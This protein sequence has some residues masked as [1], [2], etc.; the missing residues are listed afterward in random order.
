MTSL[1]ILERVLWTASAAAAAFALYRAFQL[2]LHRRF[3]MFTSYL[4]LLV[5][6][7]LGLVWID[8]YS[9]VYRVAWLTFEPLVAVG[10]AAI[11]IEA[12]LRLSRDFA[13]DW[14]F[15]ALVASGAAA[16]G[17][18]VSLFLSQID[19][20]WWGGALQLA[21]LSRAYVASTLAV[22]LGAAVVFGHILKVRTP[23]TR[24]RN[25]ALHLSLFIAYLAVTAAGF[26]DANVRDG[27][28]GVSIPNTVMSAI[29]AGVFVWWGLGMK[30]EDEDSDAVIPPS[31][32]GR[33]AS[34]DA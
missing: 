4:L 3:P 7:Y 34:S 24:G 17:V 8:A 28:Q 5:A 23:G 18:I 15:R 33:E 25:L 31:P 29:Y 9:N 6:Q 10:M 16:V 27:Q 21:V 20:V 14:Q 32:F 19:G 26:I 11:A 30:A 2:H 22:A 13:A 1:P 12:Y